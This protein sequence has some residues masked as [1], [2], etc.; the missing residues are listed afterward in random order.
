MPE[1]TVDF[2][3]WC[4]TCGKGL[5]GYSSTKNWDLNVEAC[6]YCID[7]KDDEI[8]SL[9]REITNLN[10]QIESLKDEINEMAKE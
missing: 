10:N 5:C 9:E 6:P 7:Q 4:A 8:R 3:V 1:F 2:Q